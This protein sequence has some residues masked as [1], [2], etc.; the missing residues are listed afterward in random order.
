MSQ[1]TKGT[2]TTIGYLGRSPRTTEGLT[3]RRMSE[4]VR[5]LESLDSLEATTSRR[6]SG[7][8]KALHRGRVKVW[9][10]DA[11]RP[12]KAVQGSRHAALLPAVVVSV[13]SARITHNKPATGNVRESASFCGIRMMVKTHPSK[14]VNKWR[15]LWGSS[16]LLGLSVSME[17]THD[18]PLQEDKPSRRHGI[19]VR[20]K[21]FNRRRVCH[22][23]SW[24][25]HHAAS[26]PDFRKCTCPKRCKGQRWMLR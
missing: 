13:R 16:D 21:I 26:A 12:V 3:S 8:V 9:H 23:N 6:M 18:L 24:R 25:L 15:R 22:K 2:T 20:W 19:R 14:G 7:P 10:D 11:C 5:A 1:T 4:P 17:C